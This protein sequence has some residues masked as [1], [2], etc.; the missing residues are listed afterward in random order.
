MIF[1]KCDAVNNDD[2]VDHC[3]LTSDSIR[4]KRSVP[5]F[6]MNLH[7]LHHWGRKWYFLQT[8]WN[9]WGSKG[10]VSLVRQQRVKQRQDIRKHISSPHHHSTTLAH[11]R[12]RQ[13][14]RLWYLRNIDILHSWCNNNSS[15]FSDYY[16]L[17]S[18]ECCC[19]PPWIRWCLTK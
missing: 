4:I 11:S 14:K 17:T 10:R 3:V 19:S 6:M 1:V 16:W 15:E 2:C 18:R 5:A 13:W 12:W 7:C 8:R 9:G